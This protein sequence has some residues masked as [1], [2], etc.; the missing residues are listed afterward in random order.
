MF[1][2]KGEEFLTSKFLGLELVQDDKEVDKWWREYLK[3]LF[4]ARRTEEDEESQQ[5]RLDENIRVERNRGENVGHIIKDEIVIVL[6][7]TK[8]GKSSSV[9]VIQENMLEEGDN[10]MSQIGWWKNSIYVGIGARYTKIDYTIV[11]FKFV[12]IEMKKKWSKS[13]KISSLSAVGLVKSVV[14]K[15]ARYTRMKTPMSYSY[16]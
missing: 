3:W 2:N 7:K 1:R 13:K 5:V 9:D 10:I 12:R 6:K 8:G 14:G 4:N 11:L 15:S 16:L